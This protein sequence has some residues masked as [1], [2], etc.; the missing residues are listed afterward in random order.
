MKVLNKQWPGYELIETN[1][2]LARLL[3]PFEEKN[4]IFRQLETK[5]FGGLTPKRAHR[6]A[7]N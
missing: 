4:S 3:T 2:H 1:Y 6:Q 7:K 5:F